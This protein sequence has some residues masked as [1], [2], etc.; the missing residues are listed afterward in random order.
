MPSTNRKSKELD[1]RKIEFV[2]KS[3][4][5][6]DGK[7]EEVSFL[8]IYYFK[9]HNKA[10]QLKTLDTY[11]FLCKYNILLYLAQRI[12]VNHYKRLHY[13]CRLLHQTIW[14]LLLYK[15]WRIL[16]PDSE[17]CKLQ[18]LSLEKKIKIFFKNNTWTLPSIWSI[19]E[20]LKV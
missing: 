19:E 4:V 6:Y 9:W 2:K 1:Q 8:F 20:L 18:T 11:T 10:S 14:W 13:C 5:T 17:L 7:S 15:N 16:E 3:K 12:L